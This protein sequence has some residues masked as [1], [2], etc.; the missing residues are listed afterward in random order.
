MFHTERSWSLSMLLLLWS[1]LVHLLLLLLIVSLLLLL[2][3][4]VVFFIFL[5]LI[6]TV[7][8]EL[9]TL[10][11]SSEIES[12]VFINVS[13]LIPEYFSSKIR[14]HFWEILWN[15]EFLQIFGCHCFYFP[16]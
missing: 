11:R 6:L 4:L 7:I 14:H 15:W 1:I 8:I 10:V 5:L 2:P 13:W 9:D 16:M 12:T 3:I